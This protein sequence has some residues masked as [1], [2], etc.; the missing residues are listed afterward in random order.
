VDGGPAPPELLWRKHLALLVY[1]ARSP[2]QG[3]TRDQLTGLL[4]PEK[5]ESAA[6]HSLREALR[7]I[8]HAA[9]EAAV[10][11]T[12]RAVQLSSDAVRLDCDE[13]EPL[14]AG[15]FWESAADL[16]AGQFLEGFAMP[17]S[18]G[19]EEWLAAERSHWNALA[20]RALLGH[21]SALLRTGRAAEAVAAAQR[22]ELIEPYSDLVA[23]AI[24]S[25]VAIQG[26]L[27]Q[28]T[29][30]FEQFRTR[31][32]EDLG[33]E[34]A[35]D[36]LQLHERVR[37]GRAPRPLPEAPAGP[38]H[39]RRAPLV[40]RAAE[41]DRLLSHW[42]RCRQDSQATAIVLDGDAGSGK[43]RLLE[44]FV[45]R[46]R[47]D[48]GTVS[49]VRAV[50]GDWAREGSG[51][52]GLAS[53]GLLQAPGLAG[54]APQAIAT[55]A[56]ALP[57]WADRFPTSLQHGVA[58]LPL[59]LAMGAV[60][61]A[62]LGDRP[63]VLA[64]DD[65]QWLD[66]ASL[67]G[68]SGALRDF[69]RRPLC[70]IVAMLGIPNRSE[71]EELR[72][73]VGHDVPGTTISLAPLGPDAI[74]ALALWALP[75]YDPASLERACRRIA[76]D[77]AGSPLLAVELL[78]AASAGLDLQQQEAAWPAEFHTLTQTLPGDLP[79]AVVAA[80]RIGFRRLSPDAQQ[81]LTAAAVIASGR[82]IT[83]AD[84]VRVTGMALSRVQ[85]ALDELEWQRWLESDGR[86]YGFVARLAQLVVAQDLVTKGQAARVRERLSMTG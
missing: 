46:V 32:Y 74:R 33:V 2:K 15:E 81:I 35:P 34:P 1:L 24:M 67:L 7:V 25:A 19:F 56:T 40:G 49:L 10:V 23:Q 13:L 8:R 60:L 31:L 79:D 20:V 58:A 53:G 43:S 11:S 63:L 62:A 3:R 68:L 42:A 85:P 70:V 69:A 9:G 45:A 12:E 82:R 57:D 73:R 14:V 6:R 66:R 47:L 51:W 18:Q 26:D 36:T 77:S 5:D 71:L 21:S 50:E 61:D 64:V 17:G 80:L 52:L 59:E 75:G 48:G 39:P 27:G 4:W 76:C 41:L 37:G 29:A 38:V 16:V 78:S 83:E 30:Q 65:A 54:A 72:R 44:E 22:A 28:A 86:G 55:L 84:L